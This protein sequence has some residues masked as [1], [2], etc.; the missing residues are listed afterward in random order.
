MLDY[1]W[2]W[3]EFMVRWL[4]VVAGIAWIGSSFYFIA[5]DLSLKP[6]KQLPDEAHGQAWQVHGG[7]FYNMVKYLVAPARMPDDLTWFKWEAYTTWLSGFALLTIIYYAGAGLY[8]IDVEI[9]DLE[10]W[11]AIGLSIGGII[12]SWVAYDAMC[13]SPLGRDDRLLALAGF[14]FIVALAWLYTEM[15]SARGAFVQIGVSIGTI[16]VANVAMVI[17][18]GQKKVVAALVAG[19]TPD[20]VFGRRGKQRSLH[21]NYLTLPVI[22]V[23]IGGHYP[24]VFATDYSWVILALVLVMGA[25]IRHFFNTKH[26]GDPAPWWTWAVAAAL[27]VAAILL[28]Q[29]GAPEYDESAYA[30]QGYGE[31]AELHLA[32]IELVT[33]RCAIC[34]A[35]VPQWD[36]M[37]FPPKGVML[38]TEADILAQ[39]DAIYWQVAASH[40]MPPGNVIWVEPEERAMLA[41]WRQMLK[42][43]VPMAGDAG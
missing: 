10:P 4:H 28:S 32:A 23:M 17:I 9:L 13:R 22:F 37:G 35:A 15:F 29:A 36:G 41:K 5:L 25:V 24:A 31:G 12:T 18:P 8:M 19:D 34:H 21:N 26:K 11:Q 6:G 14:V 3:S 7:G 30:E 33:E 27:L 42:S 40:A 1:L 39:V 20:P 38:E 43:G 2:M 16:M